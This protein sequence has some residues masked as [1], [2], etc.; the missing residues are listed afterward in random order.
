[1]TASVVFKI[2]TMSSNKIKTDELKQN[3]N[4]RAQTKSKQTSSNKIKIDELK[5]NQNRRAQTK[6]EQTSSNI[7]CWSNKVSNIL[8]PLY[9]I[10]TF[11]CGERSWRERSFLNSSY[12]KSRI[13]NSKRTNNCFTMKELHLL[14]TW[15]FLNIYVELFFRILLSSPFWKYSSN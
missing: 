7:L 12:V 4:R 6:S 2:I 1:M 5:Q 9:E 15:K 14:V 8:M 3:Q 11:L 10:W 13:F